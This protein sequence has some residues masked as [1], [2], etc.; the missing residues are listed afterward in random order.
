MNKLSITQTGWPVKSHPCPACGGGDV[1]P[2]RCYDHLTGR[3]YDCNVCDGR[4]VLDTQEMADLA[5]QTELPE[6][7]FFIAERDPAL[8]PAERLREMGFES[9]DTAPSPVF[10][11]AL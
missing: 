4:G 7:R 10:G 6:L 5:I 9:I 3:E 8:T 1:A 11:G 2:G